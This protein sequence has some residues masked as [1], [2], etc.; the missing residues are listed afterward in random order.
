MLGEKM[1]CAYG[2]GAA[3][4]AAIIAEANKASGAIVKVEPN[5]FR[6]IVDRCEKPLIIVRKNT[7]IKRAV[8]I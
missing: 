5:A 1:R 8:S 4:A 3:A 6:I 7:F 2:G